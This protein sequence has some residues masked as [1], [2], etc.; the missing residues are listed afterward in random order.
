MFVNYLSRFYTGTEIT[1]E[2]SFSHEMFVFI[3][4]HEVREEADQ[5]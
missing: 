5:G 2:Y 4:Y 1:E 3:I